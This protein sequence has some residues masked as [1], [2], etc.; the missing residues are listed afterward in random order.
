[1]LAAIGLADDRFGLPPTVRLAVHI[2]VAAGFVSVTGALDRVPL[3]LPG[4]VV[5]AAAAALA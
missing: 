1:V 4:G 5:A 2:A 3:L